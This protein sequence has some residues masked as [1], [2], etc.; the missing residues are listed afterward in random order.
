MKNWKTTIVGVATGIMIAI[1]NQPDWKHLTVAVLVALL[2]LASKDFNVTGGTTLNTDAS[3]S[4]PVG[5]T[6]GGK[7]N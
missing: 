6:T 1:T 7:V 4:T 3:P 5:T 2:G